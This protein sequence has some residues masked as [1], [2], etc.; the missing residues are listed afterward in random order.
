MFSRVRNLW[1]RR[2]PAPSSIVL[3]CRFFFFWCVSRI[4]QKTLYML[5]A[6]G[7]KA[8][9]LR[10][11]SCTRV[12]YWPRIL[13]GRRNG[14]KRSRILLENPFFFLLSFPFIL[15]SPFTDNS[16]KLNEYT[17]IVRYAEPSR[18]FDLFRFGP[19]FWVL[20]SMYSRHIKPAS[21]GSFFY[22]LVLPTLIVKCNNKLIMKKKI[23]RKLVKAFVDGHI[24][25]LILRIYPCLRRYG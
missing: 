6:N 16:F 5:G 14:K 18:R 9:G 21:H 23:I 1:R 7:S 4:I 20:D 25:S 12:R 2:S 22:G 11:P 19:N 8:F 17:F 13:G 24:V 15:C 3:R 10:P